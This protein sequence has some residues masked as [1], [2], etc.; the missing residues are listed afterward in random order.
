MDTLLAI[1]SRRTVKNFTGAAIDRPTL[2]LLLDLAHQAP[3]HRMTQPWR[4][5]VLDQPAIARLEA[6]LVA[7]PAIAAVPDPQKGAA[8][9]AKLRERLPTL[10]AMIQVTWERASKPDI[11]LEEHAAASAAVQNL[12]LAA[13]ALGLG[14]FWSTNQA[15][16]H[17]ETL[18]WAGADPA[19]EGFL[20]SLWLGVASDHPPAPH[21]HPLATVTRWI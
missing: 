20:G 19:R 6:F 2:T 14:S 3:T 9:L 16:G 11:D 18:R 4:F 17:P 5:V 21:R 1:R 7:T 12:L 8:K 15:L 13:T 10:G